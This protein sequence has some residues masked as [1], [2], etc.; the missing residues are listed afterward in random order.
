MSVTVRAP[1]RPLPHVPDDVPGIPGRGLG[2]TGP[3]IPVHPGS[4]FKPYVSSA[5]TPSD[6]DTA[7]AAHRVTRERITTTKTSFFGITVAKKTKAQRETHTVYEIALPR[8]V[9]GPAAGSGGH[10][11]RP[12]SW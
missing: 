5:T 7:A 3:G 4:N 9:P 12:R 2:F 6:S 10:T 8:S 11:P 1:D